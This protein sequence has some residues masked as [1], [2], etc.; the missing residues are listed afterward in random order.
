MF[1]GPEFA[2]VLSALRTPDGFY[3]SAINNI[4]SVG[5]V[6]GTGRIYTSFNDATFTGNS[7][8]SFPETLFQRTE[9]RLP[10]WSLTEEIFV[11]GNGD[12]Y[13]DN[14]R[15]GPRSLQ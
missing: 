2:G 3:E 11:C 4:F 12:L 5:N 8:L 14:R 13:C 6:P 7:P 10:G 15:C 9:N 1:F